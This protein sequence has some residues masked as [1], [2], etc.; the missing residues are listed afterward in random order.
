VLFDISLTG[1][2]K[3]PIHYVTV[4]ENCVYFLKERCFSTTT[5]EKIIFVAKSNENK[6]YIPL[7]SAFFEVVAWQYQQVEP[8][9]RR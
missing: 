2:E 5:Q 8:L 9:P 3:I 1:G 6:I 7:S 4:Y